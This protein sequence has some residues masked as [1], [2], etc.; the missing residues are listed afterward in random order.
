MDDLKTDRFMDCGGWKLSFC[1]CRLMN[2]AWANVNFPG[3]LLKIPMG[4][5]L[6]TI[7]PLWCRKRNLFSWKCCTQE[8]LT[9]IASTSTDSAYY[10]RFT[11]NVQTVASLQCT[12]LLLGM[13]KRDT[14]GVRNRWKRQILMANP[15]LTRF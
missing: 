15:C 3:S 10:H 7:A 4:R 13:Q 9:I 1:N 8:D 12:M 6:K 5:K 2:M 14:E 11:F